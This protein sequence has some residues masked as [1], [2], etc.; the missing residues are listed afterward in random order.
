MIHVIL[1]H[2]L[3]EIPQHVTHPQGFITL[4]ECD[5]K[6]VLKQN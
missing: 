2:R 6:T 4:C 3:I 5:Y 1:L